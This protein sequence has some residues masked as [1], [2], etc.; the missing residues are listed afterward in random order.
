MRKVLLF[1]TLLLH[2]VP[3]GAQ[4]PR[5]LQSWFPMLREG[6]WI[7][8]E[9]MMRDGALHADEVKMYAG[10]LDEV[11]LASNVVAVDVTQMTLQTEF[12]VTVRASERTDLQGP[13]GHRHIGFPFLSVGDRI[14]TEG[15]WRREGEFLAE[16]IEVER[17]KRLTPRLS[18]ENEHEVTARIDA[19]DLETHSV[20]L[21]GV[22][23][24]FNQGTRNKSLLLY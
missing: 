22:R 2:A 21:L 12:G 15:Q 16:E 3:A 4:S 7:K 23:V 1:L 9:G 14:E 8:V 17:S 18:Y 10:E 11:E 19:V 20:E 24:F 5:D 13:E 6:M